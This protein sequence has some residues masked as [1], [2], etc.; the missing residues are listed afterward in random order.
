ME[1]DGTAL[2]R[3]VKCFADGPLPEAV[4]DLRPTPAFPGALVKPA[5][6]KKEE[7]LI[8]VLEPTAK[9]QKVSVIIASYNSSATMETC[10]RS[11]EDQNCSGDF[12][13]IVVDSSKDGT[14]EIVAHKLPAVRLFRFSER[15][16]PGDARN[17]GFSKATSE[18]IA[19]TDADCF[20]DQNW[21]DQIIE[22]HGSRPQP[23]LGGNKSGAPNNVGESE[24]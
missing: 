13:V 4:G 7:P 19:F 22:A 2:A 20:V 9:D 23:T 14:A 16:F 12:E 17:F 21:I 24:R 18:V 5:G 8:T 11:L 6:S 1:P 10:L 3:L 15:K